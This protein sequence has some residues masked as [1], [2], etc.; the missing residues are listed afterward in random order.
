M[1]ETSDSVNLYRVFM[2]RD[3]AQQITIDN[4]VY[5]FHRSTVKTLSYEEFIDSV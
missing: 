1:V 5:L 4:E 3:K 2:T